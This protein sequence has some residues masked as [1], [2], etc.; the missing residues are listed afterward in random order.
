MAT[1]RELEYL[2]TGEWTEAGRPILRPALDV[3]LLDR[4]GQIVAKAR[5]LIDSGADFVTFPTEWAE[6]LGIDLRTE[7]APV[8]ATVAD[9]RLSNR[10]AYT[11]GFEVEMAG[12]RA[13]LPVVLFCQDMPI[14]LLGRRGFFDRFLVLMD[15]PNLRIFL[16]RS[17]S[18]QGEDPDDDAETDQALALD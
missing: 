6:L 10:Y 13:L 16:E 2:P 9:G 15:Q 11:D 7:C 18:S 14:P 1:V 8:S 5:A 3:K 12:E 4:D 17:T